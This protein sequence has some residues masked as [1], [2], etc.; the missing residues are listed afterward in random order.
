MKDDVSKIVIAF[1]GTEG[2]LEALDY[3]AKLGNPQETEMTVVHVV[4]DTKVDSPN[5]GAGLYPII[6]ESND[7]A[8]AQARSRLREN[9]LSAN[10]LVLE[11]KPA[12]KIC[13][14]AERQNADVIVI[15]SRGVSGY[16]RFMIGSISEKVAKEAEVP[17]FIVK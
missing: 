17:V 1:D 9:N 3:A 11:G 7:P 16:K 15:G 10:F 4:K 13:E 12:K 14:Y 2:S 8:I 5:Q 6:N